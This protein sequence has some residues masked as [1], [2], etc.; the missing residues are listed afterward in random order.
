MSEIWEGS[1]KFNVTCRRLADQTRMVLKK[2][3]FSDHEILEI[4]GQVS[5]EEY[6]QEKPPR[7]AET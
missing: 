2:G 7:R 4:C 3:C 6:A 5:Q 1:I